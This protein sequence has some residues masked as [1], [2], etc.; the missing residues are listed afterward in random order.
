MATGLAVAFA[1]GGPRTASEP[2][3]PERGTDVGKALGSW[4]PPLLIKLYSVDISEPFSNF[5]QVSK[6][7]ANTAAEFHG[8]G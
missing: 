6:P 4:L 5:R 1:G 3:H 7:W 8:H 2:D